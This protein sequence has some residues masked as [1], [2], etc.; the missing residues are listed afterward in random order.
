MNIRRAIF[1]LGAACALS[2]GLML[3][4]SQA[5]AATL[6]INPRPNAVEAGQILAAPVGAVFSITVYD[7]GLQ[8]G[9]KT[10]NYTVQTGNT[11]HQV[12]NKIAQAINA[13]TDLQAIG[14]TALLGSGPNYTI[15]STSVNG[16]LYKQTTTGGG[17]NRLAIQQTLTIGGT[18]TVDDKLTLTI[19]DAGLVGGSEVIVYKPN[20]GDTLADIV[21]RLRNKINNS[22]TLS[23]LSITAKVSP[24]DSSVLLIESPTFD[25]T[26]K[27]TSYSAVVKAGGT[28]TMTLGNFWGTNGSQTIAVSGTVT[29]GET[30]QFTVSNADLPDTQKTV[31]YVVQSGDNLNKIRCGLRTEIN[32]DAD[33]AAVG[34]HATCA[35]GVVTIT[36]TSPSPIAYFAEKQ[37]IK[38]EPVGGNARVKL[39]GIA[40]SAANAAIVKNTVETILANGTDAAQQLQTNS[41]IKW[42]SY[43]NH[44]DYYNSGDIPFFHPTAGP[45]ALTIRNPIDSDVVFTL[46]KVLGYTLGGPIG[47]SAIFDTS[48]DLTHGISSSVTNNYVA[49]ATAHETGHQLDR[50]YSG[51]GLVGPLLSESAE[52]KT[53]LERDIEGMNLVQPCFYN[54]TDGYGMFGDPPERSSGIWASADPHDQTKPLPTGGLGGLFSGAVAANGG[55]MCNDRSPNF[56]GTNFEKIKAAYPYFEAIKEKILAIRN[57]RSESCSQKSILYWPV[58]PTR[59]ITLVILSMAA[60]MSLIP[61]PLFAPSCLSKSGQK[62]VG[63]QMQTNSRALVTLFQT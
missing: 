5:D 24:T 18:V 61:E 59:S 14:V 57:F 10:V 35:G 15:Q 17:S 52:F 36:D 34:M 54:A 23:A 16:T 40:A 32:N 48:L 42:Y 39:C 33:L 37:M 4:P 25:A 55:D 26:E 3:A 60:T 45:N 50:L 11:V 51:G 29:V 63:H 62:M 28:E 21:V 6:T 7:A 2:F 12:A 13:D 44:D 8:T 43:A 20:T 38:C 19:F 56:G 47:Y 46:P 22:T 30:V 49:H 27:F 1:A 9:Q 31:S 41:G 58:F 53:A